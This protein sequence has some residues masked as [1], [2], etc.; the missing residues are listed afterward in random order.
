MKKLTI[1]IVGGGQLCQMMGEAIIDN[2]LPYR[3]IALDPAVPCPALPFIDSQIKGHYK[4]E[5]KIEELA[6]ASDVVSFEIELANSKILANLSRQGKAV[7]PL[8]DTL[9]LIQD[10]YIQASF[11]SEHKLPV[12]AHQQVNTK[13]DI[14]KAIESLGLPLMLK[15]RTDSYDGRGNFILHQLNELPRAMA[16][17]GG[18]RL[19]AQKFVQFSTE[20]SVIAVRGRNGEVKTFPIGENIHGKDYNILETT[21]VP[22]RVSSCVLEKARQV[23]EGVMQAFSGAGVFGIEMFVT[24]D[25]EVLIN[26]IAPRVHNSGHYTIEGC[27]TSQ[28]EQHLNAISGN[29]LGNTQLLAGPV[30][31]HN[32]NGT[33]GAY[34]KY[35]INYNNFRVNGTACINQFATLH[36]YGKDSVKP[37]RKMG[38]LTV[39]G[40]K[41][42]TVEQVL[43]RANEIYNNIQIIAEYNEH[44]H[45]NNSDRDKNG[46]RL[47][48]A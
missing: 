34:G 35:T 36:H 17:F 47:R 7:Y 3:I 25:N 22:A 2:H 15:A 6:S 44:Q 11:L 21:I 23:A 16:W 32:I 39:T 29:K 41:G 19:M 24:K 13:T 46:K 1:G 4:D 40:L 45:N 28:F 42:E 9:K 8:P 43:Q 38:H 48:Y 14:N 10:K 26:E 18:K 5:N 27:Y 33:P 31:M 20:I 37:F 12:P 30:V